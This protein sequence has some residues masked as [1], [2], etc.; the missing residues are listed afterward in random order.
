MPPL[1]PFAHFCPASPAQAV[2]QTVFCVYGLHTYVL[3]LIP[4]YWGLCDRYFSMF[5]RPVF[6]ISL[7]SNFLRCRVHELMLFETQNP[8]NKNQVK[9]LN[10]G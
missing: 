5:K 3:W 4:S 10:D 9:M 1:F 7:A 8:G 2:E 6:S